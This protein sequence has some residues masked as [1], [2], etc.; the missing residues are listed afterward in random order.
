MSEIF[1]KLSTDPQRTDGIGLGLAIVK[2]L[3]EANGGNID[4]ESAEGAG[5]T[6]RFTLPTKSRGTRRRDG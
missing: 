3:V 2:E 6:V 1:D 4:V 5:T